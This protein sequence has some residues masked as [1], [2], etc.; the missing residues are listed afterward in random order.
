MDVIIRIENGIGRITLNRPQALH[1]LNT[2][3]CR[4]MSEALAEWATDD[5]VKLL[6]IDHAEGTRGFCAGG[7]IRMVAE[8]GRQDGKAGEDFF[9]IEYTL[10]TQIKRFPKPYIACLDGVTMGGGVGISIHGS[11][12]IATEHTLF[13]MPET[14]IGLFPDVGGSWFLPRLQGELGTWLALTGA[15]L[16]GRDVLA[17]GIATHFVA[18]EKLPEVKARILA[19]EA[20][21]AVLADYAEAAKIPAYAEHLDTINHCFSRP[22]ITDICLALKMADND[23]ATAQADIL[24]TRSP[25]SMA[26][27]LEQLRRGAQMSSFEDIMRMEYRIACHIIRTHD[28]SEGVRAVIEDKDHAPKWSPETPAGVSQN[29]VKAM[30]APVSEE[31]SL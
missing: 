6:M 24:K 10:N 3:M 21:D 26:V 1:A 4:M 30:F 17:A 13:A 22:T 2:D 12:R 19:G 14:G 29:L 31:L 11:H 28:F 16:K 8:S 7:D 25:L 15:R 23:W 18:S 9:R 5:R 20:P 27:S